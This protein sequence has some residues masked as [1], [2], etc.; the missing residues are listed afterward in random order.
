MNYFSVD[1][2]SLGYED[3]II[4]LIMS[5]LNKN[6]KGLSHKISERKMDFLGNH[7]GLHV[8]L[9]EPIVEHA[10][11]RRPQRKRKAPSYSAH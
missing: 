2:S 4:Y 6:F 10:H 11:H 8:R 7:G 9:I 5:W 1:G 3:I